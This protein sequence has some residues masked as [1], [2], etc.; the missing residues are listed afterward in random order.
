MVTRYA[1][2]HEAFGGAAVCLTK[3]VT[4]ASFAPWEIDIG[5][6]LG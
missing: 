2:E 4:S 5:P 6:A 3:P 1:E